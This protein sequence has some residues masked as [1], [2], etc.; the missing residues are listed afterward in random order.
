MADPDQNHVDRAKGRFTGEQEKI[1]G[2]QDYRH[3][4]D[5]DD[6]DAVVIDEH[7]K[8]TTGIDYGYLDFVN[9]SVAQCVEEA[10]ANLQQARVKYAT[11]DSIGLSLGLDAEDDGFGVADGKVL[12]GDELLAP[13]RGI[14]VAQQ[15]KQQART[16]AEDRD[17]GWKEVDYDVLR[18]IDSPMLRLF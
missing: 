8:V 14:F 10:A 3:V 17:I 2:Y 12:D 1:D 4:L 11:T 16:L 7:Q 5:R 9:A 13:V 6:V 15:V 18:G